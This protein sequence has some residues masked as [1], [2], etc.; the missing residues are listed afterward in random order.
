MGL[1]PCDA[2]GARYTGGQQTAYP[3]LVN[4]G[5]QKREKRRLC[6][7]CFLELQGWLEGHLSP[8]L[9]ESGNQ[10]CCVCADEEAPY[11]V[12]VTV[13][14][15]GAER[16]DWYGRSCPACADQEVML[17]L[18]ATQTGLASR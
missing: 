9:T 16:E 4:G 7:D 14:A 1:F 13:Y 2:H 11:A 8:A 10:R 3:A 5:T 15:K 6:P 17:A 18:F 12:F